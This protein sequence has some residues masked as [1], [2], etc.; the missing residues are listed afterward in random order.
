MKVMTVSLSPNP[1]PTRGE[2]RFVSRIRDFHIKRRMISLSTA[3]INAWVVAFFFPLARILA[4]FAAASPFD[5]P[6]LGTRVRLLLGLA[7]SM[8]IVP[9]LPSV[10]SLDPA[11]GTG[12]LILAQQLLVGFAMGFAIRLVFTAVD[13]AGSLISLQMGLGFATSYDPQTA[14]QTVVI[15]EFM[16]LLALLVFLAINGHL[17]VVATLAHSFTALPVGTQGFTAD[18]WGKLANAGAVIFSSGLLLALPI[19]VALMIG[20]L[21]LTILSR[22][23]PQLNL[24]AIG[25]P[26][27]IALGF[28]ALMVSLSYLG[29]PLQQLFEYGLESMLGNLHIV[30]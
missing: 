18:S 14:G 17:M 24:M 10:P 5:H 30:R 27:T 9:V 16:G 4:V 28:A 8:A 21:A 19:V 1:S 2:R 3:E 25:F 13:L 7:I 26:L 20:N 29:A 22:A 23:A 15:S 6:A 11:S 12:L